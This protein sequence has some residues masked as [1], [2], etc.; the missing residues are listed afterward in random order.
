MTLLRSAPSWAWKKA[1]E[2]DDGDFAGVAARENGSRT[3]AGAAHQLATAMARRGRWRRSNHSRRQLFV[4]R[5]V[6]LF[7]FPLRKFGRVNEEKGTGVF[8]V[9]GSIPAGF[10]PSNFY[11][12]RS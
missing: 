10:A 5:F 12:L 1:A 6:F 8:T 11:S 2:D 3:K 7:L 4:A 9:F